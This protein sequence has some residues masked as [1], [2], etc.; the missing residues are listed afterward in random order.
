MIS[1]LLYDDPHTVGPFRILARLGG[2]GMGTV[3]LARSADGRTVA[4]KTLHT[5]LAA[6]TTLRTRFRLEADAARVIGS[7][8]GAAVVDADPQ[9]PTP[10]LATEY[11]LGPPLDVAVEGGGPL[12][13]PAVRALGAALAAG[14]EQLHRSE[15]VH[16]DLKPSNVLVTA[17][18]PRIIDFGIARAF[19][20]EHLTNVG[21]AMGTP[22]FMSPE[23]AA[24]LEHAAAGDVFALAGVLVF[25]ATGIGPFGG[26]APTDLLYRVRYSEPDL[27]Q[28]P[29]SLRPLLVRCLAKDPAQRPSI[30]ELRTALGAVGGVPGD[31]RGFADLLPDAVLREIARRSDEVWRE[32]PHRL[33]P[34]VPAEAPAARPASAS[35]VSRRRLL[36]VSGGALLGGGLLGGGGWALFGGSGGGGGGGTK[37]DAVDR[38]KPPAALWS[39]ALWCPDSGG[40][41]MTVG[42]NLVMRAGIVLCGIN[43]ESGQGT[44]QA[45]IEETW[46]SATDG[47][48]VYGLRG[49][50]DA[51][52]LAVCEVAQTDGEL[53]KPLV[54]LS[55]FTGKE[56]YNQL[57]CVVDGVAYLVAKAAS[58]ERW[59]L[60][61]ADL[62]TGKE[63]WRS[64]VDGPPMNGLQAQAAPPA[65]GGTVVGSRV[66]L[67]G[68]PADDSKF[69][70]LSVHDKDTG[71]QLWRLSVTF[72]G[73]APSRLVTD[74]RNIYVGAEDLTARR[75]SDGELEWVV[76]MK[77]GSGNSG[78]EE[79]RYSMPVVQDGVVYCTDG[80]QGLIAVDALS[81][82]M[83][84]QEKGL[85]GRKSTRDA[86]PAIGKRYAY[87]ADDKGVRAID[88]QAHKA[89]WTYEA[90]PVVLTADSKGG[91]LYVR[92]EKRTIALPLA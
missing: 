6:D 27:G 21:S 89:V 35:G 73:T 4:V 40:E 60:V 64:P 39:T 69:L 77:G 72:A 70:G 44:W 55:A 48:R 53:G 43:A 25:A 63:R 56:Q 42:R 32:P 15:V 11:V 57:L 59:Y 80:D 62:G 2:G 9:A 29:E 12:P 3:F 88:L 1:A 65:L 81:G 8:H 36:A 85:S 79:R 92:Q 90:T 47:T 10:W 83:N 30:T 87:C 76:G 82:T 31:R 14:L 17:Q 51:A 20:D 16:R 37:K 18:G 61:A 66:V 26:G 74:D 13:E 19:G 52:S 34:P 28:V 54:E 46:R 45:N 24:G 7:E 67:C 22:A 33:P 58:G 75:I 68:N 50:K 41:V 86:A 38:P 71:R 23:Q 84:W 78:G 49:Y 5:R 91:R